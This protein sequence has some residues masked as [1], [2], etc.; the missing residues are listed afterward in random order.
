MFFGEIG[1][2]AGMEGVEV[3]YLHRKYTGIFYV[4]TMLNEYQY[5]GLFAEM[6][7]SFFDDLKEGVYFA[8]SIL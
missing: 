8:V 4:R 7:Q 3:L 1:Y 2:L 6:Q 5:I